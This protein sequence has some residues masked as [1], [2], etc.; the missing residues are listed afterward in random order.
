M[1]KLKIVLWRLSRVFGD[2]VAPYSFASSITDE[3]WI[4]EKCTYMVQ[5]NIT[6]FQNIWT[7]WRLFCGVY[8]VF[9]VT[10]LFTVVVFFCI[11][12]R[13]GKNCTCSK[14][15]SP[16]YT[17][18][19]FCIM[20]DFSI[21]KS[22]IEILCYILSLVLIL[23]RKQYKDRHPIPLAP[24]SLRRVEYPK[25]V[26]IL[27]N[28]TSL[29]FKT[30]EKGEDCF[31]VIITCIWWRGCSRLLYFLCQVADGKELHV[32]KESCASL[33]TSLKFCIMK[34]FSIL[35]LKYKFYVIF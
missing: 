29:N 26:H 11:R 10:G 8:H 17:G 32:F 27:C 2:M 9:L 5:F 21:I 20:K 16:W 18:F 31:V 13:T 34:D 19:K 1:K 22:P 4:P 7:S 14:K 3:G 6:E 15:V 25:Y 24:A 23:D 33:Y 35:T 28:L 12:W 30:F